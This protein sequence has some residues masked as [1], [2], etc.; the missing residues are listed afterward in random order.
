MRKKVFSMVR[1]PNNPDDPAEPLYL[2]AIYALGQKLGLSDDEIRAVGCRRYHVDFL[3]ELT[4][5]NAY[6]FIRWMEVS[7][8]SIKGEVRFIKLSAKGI[9]SSPIVP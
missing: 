6:R 7:P 8:A 3:G 2:Y 5:D 9:T 4:Q 1:P